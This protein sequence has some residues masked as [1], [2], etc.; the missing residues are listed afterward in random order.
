MN[1][2]FCMVFSFH[3]AFKWLLQFSVITAS[4][5]AMP[6]AAQ[7]KPQTNVQTIVVFGDSL[8]AAYNIAQDEGWVALLQQR[9]A[10][11]KYNYQVINASI[12]GETTSGGLSRFADM[13]KT[14]KPNIVILELG[15]ND[16]LR[17]LSA[18]ETSNNLDAM[19]QQAKAKKAQVLLLGMKIPPNYGIKYNRQFSQNYQSLAKKHQLKLVPFFLEGVAGNP[20]LMQADGL[21][22]TAA[23][24]PKILENVW[25]ILVKMLKK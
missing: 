12:S 17:G 1:S 22:P 20:N 2:R 13:L 6:A 4:L 19:I 7:T 14:K 3:M 18:A 15:G 10:L 23:A 8:S 25:P 21:H 24:Q 11:K 16:G 9:L 5:V